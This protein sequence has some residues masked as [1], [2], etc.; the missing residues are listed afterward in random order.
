MAEELL[1]R[2]PV[3]EGDVVVDDGDRDALTEFCVSW[4]GFIEENFPQFKY[5]TLSKLL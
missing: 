2:N 1:L 5:V 3:V 4:M